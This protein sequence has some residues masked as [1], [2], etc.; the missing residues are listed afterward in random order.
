MAGT[1]WIF[2]DLSVALWRK[3]VPVVLGHPTRSFHIQ[4]PSPFVSHRLRPVFGP[5]SHCQELEAE[6]D[7][8]FHALPLGDQFRHCRGQKGLVQIPI[9]Q[10]SA[11]SPEHQGN[12][13]LGMMEEWW[14]DYEVVG[15]Q[16]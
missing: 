1:S 5:T 14:M 6:E 9:A 4:K 13:R 3:H 15:S 8:R 12:D 10:S 11:Q 2:E 7:P 16:V